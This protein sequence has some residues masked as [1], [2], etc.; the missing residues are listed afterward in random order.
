[1]MLAACMESTTATLPEAWLG[2]DSWR[3]AEN[4]RVLP[5]V[6]GILFSAGLLLACFEFFD[7]LGF[8]GLGFVFLLIDK[9]PLLGVNNY[10][11]FW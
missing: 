6:L 10:F 2:L 8:F 3:R 11:N 1:M 4:K 9:S 5:L 7:W